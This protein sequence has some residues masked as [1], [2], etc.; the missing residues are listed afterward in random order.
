M[1]VCMYDLISS[2]GDGMTYLVSLS[3]GSRDLC[4]PGANFQIAKPLGLVHEWG[5]GGMSDWMKL[6]KMS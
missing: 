6:L 4:P 3:L 5:E 2:R 1:Y